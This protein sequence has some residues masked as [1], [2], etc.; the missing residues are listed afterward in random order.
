MRYTPRVKF[1]GISGYDQFLDFV[2]PK[3]RKQPE[4]IVQ[5]VPWSG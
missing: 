2:I 3:S 4:R 1:P 5:P